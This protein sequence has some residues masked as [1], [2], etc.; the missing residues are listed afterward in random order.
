MIRITDPDHDF[1]PAG[2]SFVRS[3]TGELT[4]DWEQGIHT[5]DS[6]RTQAVSGWVGGKT[7]RTKDASF[8]V[9][10]PKAVVALSSV[11]DRPLP[12]S[13]LVMVSAVARAVASPGNKGPY[14]SEP[15]HARIVLRTKVDDLE[16]L[17]MTADGRVASR[18][19]VEYRDGTL[20]IEIPAAG[21]THWYVLRS[22]GGVTAPARGAAADRS[23]RA[24]P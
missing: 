6:P 7:L 22:R 1:I 13:H 3:D 16:L 14:L 24:R 4:R 19:H 8:D 11:D 2:Q 5:I 20:T 10:T 12:E 18:P 9:T 15:V 17:S 21:G 23:T